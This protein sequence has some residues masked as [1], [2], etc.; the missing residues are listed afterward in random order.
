MRDDDPISP[1]AILAALVLLGC[2][3]YLVML[4][5][6][7]RPAEPVAKPS[8]VGDPARC[9]EV[10]GQCV[11]V[12]DLDFDTNS[13]ER[14]CDQQRG[15]TRIEAM[16]GNPTALGTCPTALVELESNC[17]NGCQLAHD[18]N[19]I[20]AGKAQIEVSPR[21]NEAASCH[22]HGEMALTI[23]GTCARQV[24]P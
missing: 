19:L 11:A 12:A 6:P 10:V 22:A 21:A 17:P 24:A 14:L 9:S 1:T 3:S 20:I 8:P 5:A 13:S 23:R 2:V 7:S 4:F 16:L 18:R 15:R